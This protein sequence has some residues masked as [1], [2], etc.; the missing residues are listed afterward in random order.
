MRNTLTGDKS[1]WE[2]M[3]IHELEVCPVSPYRGSSGPVDPAFGCFPSS[4]CRAEA[5]NMPRLISSPTE[6]KPSERAN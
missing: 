1:K 4:E 3:E 2:L 5:G 6:G